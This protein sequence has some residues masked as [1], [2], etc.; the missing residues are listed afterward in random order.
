MRKIGKIIAS[1]LSVAMII[2]S[3]GTSCVFADNS[4]LNINPRNKDV[5]DLVVVESMGYEFTLHELVG[6]DYSVT[7]E[8]H[9]AENGDG[10]LSVEKTRALL[11][12]LGMNDTEVNA[13]S[14][15]ELS[16]IANI[17]TIGITVTYSKENEVTGETVYLPE[18]IALSG[19]EL[20]LEQRELHASSKDQL[21]QDAYQDY[22]DIEN[23]IID[24]VTYEVNS[25]NPYVDTYMRITVSSSLVSGTSATYKLSTYATWLTMPSFR[26]KDAVGVSANYCTLVAGSESGYYSYKQALTIEGNTTTS[27][28]RTNITGSNLKNPVNGNWYGAAGIFNLPNDGY[29]SSTD[30]GVECTNLFAYI[31]CKMLVAQTSTTSFNVVG[32]YAHSK[33]SVAF[34]VGATFAEGSGGVSLTATGVITQDKREAVKTV[35]R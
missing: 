31:T 23:G 17:E 34:S 6:S 20:N 18:D 28:I 16:D 4:G 15:E 8:Y 3:A 27:T 14:D 7:R 26:W 10:A 25:S 32:S 35:Y 19:A 13:H 33:L 1:V 2:T 29:D 12:A 22:I 21:I 11:Y 24:P 5:A 30:S 9:K